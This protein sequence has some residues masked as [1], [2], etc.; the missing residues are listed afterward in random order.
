M[1]KIPDNTAKI[2]KDHLSEYSNSSKYSEKVRSKASEIL[3]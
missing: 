2:L 3:S 1:G